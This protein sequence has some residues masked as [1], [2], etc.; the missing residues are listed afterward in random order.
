MGKWI[1]PLTV[2]FFP[3]FSLPRHYVALPLP[4]STCANFFCQVHKKSLS[5]WSMKTSCFLAGDLPFFTGKYPSFLLSRVIDLGNSISGSGRGEGAKNLYPDDEEG[6]LGKSAQGE[7]L[8]HPVNAHSRRMGYQC[9]WDHT[10]AP[11]ISDHT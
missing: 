11:S 3:L 2:F 5:T 8:T 6:F 7:N 10:S 4:E 1:S 9:F